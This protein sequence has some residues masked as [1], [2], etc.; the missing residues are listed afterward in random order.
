MKFT[1]LFALSTILV[2]AGYAQKASIGVPLPGEAVQ[3]GSNI[4]VEID[5]PNSLTPSTEV[6]IGIGFLSCV[7]FNSSA[8]PS[9]SEVLGSI[10]YSGPFNPQYT[11]V[12]SS[13]PPHQNFTVTIP[14][15]AKSGPAQIAVTHS[16]L[17]GAGPF[18]FNEVFNITVNVA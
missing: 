3:A 6:G 8:C 16:S 5:R 13:K 7:D 1:Q 11:N 15:T 12:S 4:T 2:T 9:P 14:S 10:L 18:P 17:V